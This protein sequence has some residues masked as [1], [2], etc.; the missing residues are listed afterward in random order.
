MRGT[1]R[2]DIQVGPDRGHTALN[3]AR[4]LE[5]FIQALVIDRPVA[6]Q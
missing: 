5:F 1:R 4:M 2:A 6:V 3:S